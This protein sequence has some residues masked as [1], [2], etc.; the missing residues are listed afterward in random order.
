MGNDVLAGHSGRHTL[1]HVT[2]HSFM[3]TMPPTSVHG[4]E[5]K[6]DISSD[7]ISA[8]FPSQYSE[9]KSAVPINSVI[10]SYDVHG[11]VLID[12]IQSTGFVS[13]LVENGMSDI[14]D[15][16][17]GILAIGGIGLDPTLFSLKASSGNG[18]IENVKFAT[19]S[20]ESRI[21][22]LSLPEL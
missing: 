2:S 18:E 21:A 16:Q 17:R 4:V 19:P 20:S 1:N 10:S 7:V 15:T 12:R 5:K 3:G 22:I 9:I 14:D 8:E 11:P 13:T 6:L